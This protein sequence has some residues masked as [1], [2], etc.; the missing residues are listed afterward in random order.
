MRM[1]CRKPPFDDATSI[2]P[3]LACLTLLTILLGTIEV[4][5]SLFGICPNEMDKTDQKNRVNSIIRFFMDP[6]IYLVR[7]AIHA[8]SF[9]LSE[10]Y[11]I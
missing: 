6:F 5:V 1:P 9:S 8:Q 7:Y 11:Q 10:R 2:S 3:F 4:F